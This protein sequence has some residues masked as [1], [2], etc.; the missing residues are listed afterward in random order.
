MKFYENKQWNKFLVVGSA[1][2]MNDWVPNHLQW[3]VK[4]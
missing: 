1:P 3:F 2:Y 4:K